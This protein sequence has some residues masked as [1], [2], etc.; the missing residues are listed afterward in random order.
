M[1]PKEML[2]K[3]HALRDII[4]GGMSREAII[5]LSRQAHDLEQKA[6]KGA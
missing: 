5:H 6:K 2:E 1:T 4:K 3:A